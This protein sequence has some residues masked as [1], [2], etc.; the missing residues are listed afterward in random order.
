[1]SEEN[2]E[3]VRRLSSFWRD[4][5]YSAVEELCHPDAVVDVSRNV[6]NPG[7]HSGIDGLREFM[8]T[9][10]EAWESLMLTRE[11]LIA[12]GDQVVMANRI[13]G[14]GRASGVRT[15]TLAFAVV[16]LEEGKVVRFTG[17]FRDRREALEA[18]GLSE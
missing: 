16:T 18:A 7:I 6:F 17:G 9:I 5:D 1:M 4:R 11:E 10:D 13:S 3:I 12:A 8:R 14:R 15:E 2:V